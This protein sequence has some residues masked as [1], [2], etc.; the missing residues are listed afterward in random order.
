[1]KIKDK[2][3]EF[4]RK[5]GLIKDGPRIVANGVSLFG[6]PLLITECG[7][8]YVLIFN[9][10]GSVGKFPWHCM[11]NNVQE[12]ICIYTEIYQYILGNQV[13]M[14]LI[15]IVLLPLRNLKFAVEVNQSENQQYPVCDYLIV[16]EE[17]TMQLVQIEF[18]FPN[19]ANIKAKPEIQMR[20]RDITHVVNLPVFNG[21]LVMTAPK[22][23]TAGGN[24][25]TSTQT[26]S[27]GTELIIYNTTTLNVMWKCTFKTLLETIEISSYPDVSI[28]LDE[29]KCNS[30]CCEST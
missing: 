24:K 15:N 25:A 21:V 14:Q 11:G 17:G 27:V 16:N 4:A 13:A 7:L 12:L 1:M 5:I 30:F 8:G 23:T 19:T 3:I 29:C 20:A 6:H 2:R 26:F 18:D 22:S 28:D 9:V 10:F